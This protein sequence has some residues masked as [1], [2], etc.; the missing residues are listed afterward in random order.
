MFQLYQN[1]V[2]YKPPEY[3]R[4]LVM[5]NK[6]HAVHQFT[7]YVHVITL[8]CIA[9]HFLDPELVKMTMNMSYN[10]KQ[11]STTEVLKQNPRKRS[12]YT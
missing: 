1:T 3:I 4:A 12:G 11:Y 7:H 6:G 8:H 5:S 10:T 2:G 9:L